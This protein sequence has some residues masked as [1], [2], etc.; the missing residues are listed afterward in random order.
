MTDFWWM[1]K[2]DK[3]RYYCTKLV[4]H[5]PLEEQDSP[6]N[7]AFKNPDLSPINKIGQ[8]STGHQNQN[9][10]R[11]LKIWTTE[12]KS[13][14]LIGPFIIDIDNENGDLDDA[15]IIT[16][17]ALYAMYSKVPSL[18]LRVFF[19][20]HKGFNIEIL[21]SA[22]NIAGSLSQQQAKAKLVHKDIIRTLQFGMN[23][24]SNSNYVG[25]NGTLIDRIHDYI[26]LHGSTNVWIE[27][28][29]RKARRKVELAVDEF[30]RLS[31]RQ[32][33]DMSTCQL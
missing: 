20:G 18:H 28:G 24:Q 25:Q 29:S 8:W 15:L 13:E 21:P 11:S 12:D 6:A 23:G 16:R 3:F 9:V 14:S 19:T 22:L 17:Q 7:L 31:L 32:I 30:D 5:E 2:K 33:L 27:N 10:Y 26:R 4:H 1:E